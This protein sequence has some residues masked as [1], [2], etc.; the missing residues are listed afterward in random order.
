MEHILSILIFF[1]AFAAAIGFIVDKDAIRTYGITVTA[2]EF[3]LSCFLW[4]GFDNNVAGM[5]FAEFIPVISQYGIAY[6]LGVTVS[7]YS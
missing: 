6:N 3:I 1:P 2:I 5:Q 7:L 4:A